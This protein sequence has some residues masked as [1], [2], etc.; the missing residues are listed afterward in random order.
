[1]TTITFDTLR[2]AER[3]EKAGVPREQAAAIELRDEGRDTP[4]ACGGMAQAVS[5]DGLWIESRLGSQ[6]GTRRSEPG[7]DPC[8]A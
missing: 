7:V 6:A 4:H 1:M 8:H 5:P 3:L 2:F